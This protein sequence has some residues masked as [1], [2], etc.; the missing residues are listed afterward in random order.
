MD[1]QQ[2]VKETLVQIA[3]GIEDAGTEFQKSNLKSKIN[4]MPHFT[5]K[6]VR[7]LKTSTIEFDVAVTANEQTTA[8]GSAGITVA[9]LLGAG[10]KSEQASQ[11]QSISR[12]KFLV[13][14][15]QPSTPID[16]G[17]DPVDSIDSMA[18]RNRARSPAARL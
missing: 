16:M 4:P 5:G 3:R 11:N 10:L 7:E 9:G 8:G 6:A 2:F 12:V 18:L 15:L 13:D 14:M 1:L 17:G